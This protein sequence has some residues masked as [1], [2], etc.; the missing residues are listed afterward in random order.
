VNG[1]DDY[2][3]LGWEHGSL[4]VQRL[5]AMLAPITFLFADGRQVSPMQVAPWAY[6]EG[7]QD[8]PGILRRLRGEWPC[9]PFGYSVPA[10]G[11]AKEWVPL[12]HPAAPDEEAH[13][14]S[15]NNFWT[16]DDCSAASLALSLD[17]PAT[18]PVQRVERTITPD[19]AQPAVDIEFRIYVRTACRLP[20]GLHPTFRLPQTVGTAAIERARFDHGRT[21][22][23]N[24]D[25]SSVFAIDRNFTSLEAVPARDETVIDASRLPFG[26]DTEDLLQ[27]NGIDGE[28]A[29]ANY[30]EG[31]R[32]RLSWQKEHFPSLLLWIS[33]RGRK[34]S[35]W[36]GR[37]LALGM[38]PI[39]SPFGLG[40]ATAAED[41]PIARSGTPTARDFA[42]GEV[43]A[44]RYR[45]AAEAL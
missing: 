27:L 43:F 26:F 39:C 3:G 17:Y 8:L 31:Y 25:A 28:V 41:N 37:H 30:A 18:S 10:D 1:I 44:T 36:N 14:H 2:R 11:F 13:G 23:G 38:E 4:V 35:P 16:W 6:E 9:V 12:M 19:P 42:A 7:A 40:P 34:M 15:S 24:V 45:I 21:Y 20:I 22:P 32:V 29:L 33:N 5:G